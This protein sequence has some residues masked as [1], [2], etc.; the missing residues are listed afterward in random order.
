MQHMDNFAALSVAALLAFALA[1]IGIALTI[2]W[3]RAFGAV[4]DE[5]DRTMHEGRIPKGGGAP[6]LIAAFVAIVILGSPLDPVLITCLASLAA[7]SLINDRHSVPFPIRLLAHFAAAS[8]IALSLPGDVNALQGTVPYWI[9]RAVIV[10]ALAWM[11][12]LYNFMDGIN[13][14]AGVETIA[15]SVGYL[16]IVGSA[17][18][19]SAHSPL[20][21]AAIGATVG[22]LIWNLRPVARVFLGDAGSVPLG[23]LMGVLM[24]DLAVRGYLAAA[25]ILP[26]TFVADASLTLLQR[27]AAGEKFWQAHKS[28]HY[29]RAAQRLGAHLPVVGMVTCANGVLIVLALWSLAAPWLALAGAIAT[30]ALLFW[31]QDQ[32][33]RFRSSDSGP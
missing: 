26:A 7:L 15:I 22:F 6:L 3:L 33:G 1:A 10:I 12:N 9:D 18:S 31:A 17:P 24:L 11:M 23:L 14:I 8:A 20:A 28:H 30:V 29:Q 27:M 16:A 4:A 5:N 2:P 13:G 21:A 25:L 32:A 19:G